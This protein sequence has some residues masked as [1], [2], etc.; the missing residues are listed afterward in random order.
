MT[1]DRKKGK[2]AY[3]LLTDANVCPGSYLG[4]RRETLTRQ[5]DKAG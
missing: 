2:D 5:V 1:F 3:S 4:K